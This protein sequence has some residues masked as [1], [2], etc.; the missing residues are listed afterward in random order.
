MPDLER[1]HGRPVLVEFADALLAEDPDGVDAAVMKEPGLRPLDR[2]HAL[3]L[4]AE[5]VPGPARARWLRQALDVY[6]T[7]GATLMIDRVRRLLRDAGGSV[8]RRR[9]SSDPLAPELAEKGV[10]RREYEVLQLLGEGLSNAE[11][12]ARLYVSIRTVESHVSSLLVKLDA[13]TR[14]Q[15]TARHAAI[16]P[17]P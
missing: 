9:H 16:N 13:R 17:P 2:A 6:E 3:V 5:I 12:A 11:I 10:T 1:W 15:L 8:P 4:A 14:G 7:A